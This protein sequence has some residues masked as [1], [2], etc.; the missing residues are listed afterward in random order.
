[1]FTDGLVDSRNVDLPDETL[2]NYT[3]LIKKNI[4][5][6]LEKLHDCITSYWKN[7]GGA[8]D[9]VTYLLLEYV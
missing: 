7:Q 2:E 4:D 1:M 8:F 5:L 3:S 6:P 9:D